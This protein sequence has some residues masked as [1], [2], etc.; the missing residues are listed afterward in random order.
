MEIDFGCLPRKRI[1]EAMGVTRQAVDAW[2][3]QGCPVN[4]DGTMGLPAVIAWYNRR[5]EERREVGGQK[6]ENLRLQ[7]IKLQS[8][9]DKI[10]E[11]VIERNDHERIL[12]SRAMSVRQF[13]EKSALM[14]CAKF[15]GL[16]LDEARIALI[17]FCK[18]ASNEY[19]GRE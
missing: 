4:Q 6:E 17:E 19:A 5:E 9:I 13:F 11:N 15:V 12:T 8:Q 18:R 10:R 16:S 7:N 14:N 1:H 2:V 3:A